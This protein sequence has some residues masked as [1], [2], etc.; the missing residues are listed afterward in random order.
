MRCSTDIDLQDLLNDLKLSQDL[1]W[2]II[3]IYFVWPT[4]L[5]TFP[6]PN[7]RCKYRN[8]RSLAFWFHRIF[9]I[10]GHGGHFGPVT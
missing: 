8:P 10:Y 7:A 6:R 3:L 9:N 5:M 2:R 4:S 1:P